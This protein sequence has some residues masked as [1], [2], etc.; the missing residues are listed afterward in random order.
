MKKIILSLFC[1]ALYSGSFAQSLSL[2]FTNGD[3]INSGSTVQFVGDPSDETIYAYINITNLTAIAKTVSIKK[4]IHEGDTIPGTWNTFCW[5]VCYSD[6]TYISPFPQTIQPGI[7]SDGFSGDY[8]P[9]NHLGIST[10]SYVFFNVDDRNDSVSVVVEFKAS[11]ASV[12]NEPDG[13]VKFSGAYPNPAVNDVY[14]E[15][16]IPVTFNRASIIISNMLGSRVKEVSLTERSGKASITVTDLTNG[17]YFYSL[18]ADDQLL[19]TRKFVVR[20]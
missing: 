5:G 6:T 19:Q 9:K 13:L 20:R 8:S 14:V 11:P 3:P 1:L 16:S 2:S 17:I 18:I 7:T 10:I 4:V 12:G 15:Y